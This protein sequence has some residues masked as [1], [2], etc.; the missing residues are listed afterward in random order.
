VTKA[1]AKPTPELPNIHPV[2]ELASLREEIAMLQ[3]RADEIRDGLLAEGAA[4]VRGDQFTAR[5]TDAKREVLDKKA[6]IE[7]FGDKI[8]APFIRTTTYKMVKITEN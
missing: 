1:K 4:L 7:A 6:L 3:E 5:I 2:D 8:I